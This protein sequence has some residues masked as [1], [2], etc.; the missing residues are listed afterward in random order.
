[1]YLGSNSYI[2]DNRYISCLK[3]LPNVGHFFQCC[4]PRPGVLRE[5]GELLRCPHDRRGRKKL[6]DFFRAEIVVK[7]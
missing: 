1:M 4:R 5:E 3:R 6:K 7:P 2:S